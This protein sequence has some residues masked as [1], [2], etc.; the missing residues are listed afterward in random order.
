MSCLNSLTVYGLCLWKIQ[1]NSDYDHVY[2]ALQSKIL[3]KFTYILPIS[4]FWDYKD[5]QS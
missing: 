4:T 3:E 1:T 2:L 5:C